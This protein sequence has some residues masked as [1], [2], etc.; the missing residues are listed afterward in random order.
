MTTRLPFTDYQIQNFERLKQR[1]LEVADL[2]DQQ[3]NTRHYAQQIRQCTEYLRLDN[4]Y[5]V[6][7]WYCKHRHCPIC[8][9][10]KL[11]RWRFRF[12]EVLDL[13]HQR[14]PKACWLYLTLTTPNRPVTELREHLTDMTQ[15]FTRLTRRSFWKKNISGFI[16]FTEVTQDLQQPDYAHPH[17]HCL[18]L[19]RPSMYNGKDYVSVAQ[20][21]AYWAEALGVDYDPVVD[22]QRLSRGSSEDIQQHCMD[23]FSYSMKPRE[24]LPDS[25]WFLT[26]VEQTKGVRVITPGGVL[27]AFLSMETKQDEREELIA[28]K[29]SNYYLWQQQLGR[30]IASDPR[31]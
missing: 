16:R 5:S 30:Y 28:E 6:R 12:Q 10:R 25:K 31:E 26:M 1:S 4:L 29:K 13:V 17:F 8:Q 9:S 20:W 14:A 22:C 15:A 24:E 23:K 11:L 27:R 7:S 3:P 18:L 2:F 19:V 21:Q